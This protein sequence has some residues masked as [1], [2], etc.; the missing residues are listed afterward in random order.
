MANFIQS[1]SSVIEKSF[2]QPDRQAARKLKESIINLETLRD[3]PEIA[4][5]ILLYVSTLFERAITFVAVATD[6]IAEKGIGINS[7]KST[8]PTSPLMFKIPLG[9][10]SVFMDAI[11]KRRM[12]YGLSSDEILKTHLYN[13][14]GT[15]HSSK[16]L[17]LPLMMS[18][19]VI[20]LIYADFGQ[21]P[22]TPVQTEY[23]EIVSRYAGLVLDNSQY[24]KKFDKLIKHP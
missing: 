16:I 23:L 20:A 15:P 9:Q 13:T 2:T 11:E 8:G 12:Y 22:P 3:P 5:E 17:L 1:F 4:L 7:G 10:Q 6:L 19:K 18:G 14:I 21:T 24:R